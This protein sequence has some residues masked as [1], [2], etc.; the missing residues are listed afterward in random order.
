MNVVVGKRLRYFHVGTA[1]GLSR[2]V[3]SLSFLGPPNAAM[4]SSTVSRLF[5]MAPRNITT[6]DIVKDH[7]LEFE[8]S[9]IVLRVQGDMTKNIYPFAEQGQRLRWLR[10]AE[11]IPT[12]V[13]FAAF[14]S[15]P[16]SGMSQF[17]SGKRR[18]PMDKALQ[19]RSRI[20][21]FDPIWLWEGDKRGLSYDLRIRIEA[22]EEK[23]AAAA[24]R[25]ASG[26]R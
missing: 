6:C 18:V 15:W 17:E 19:L 3:N 23:E 7:T 9:R 20:P 14:M 21:G 12:A 25:S 1:E 26:K 11:R 24:K 2:K 22:E 4:T 16:Q 5:F 10:Q 8:I 13:A